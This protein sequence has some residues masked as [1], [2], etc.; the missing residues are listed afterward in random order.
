MAM[1]VVGFTSKSTKKYSEPD[2]FLDRFR[3]KARY[4]RGAL[5][6]GFK[7]VTSIFLRNLHF[8]F[9][10]IATSHKHVVN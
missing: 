6:R 8:T 1:L 5:Y 3:G 2:I 10:F 4:Q 9:I 7:L